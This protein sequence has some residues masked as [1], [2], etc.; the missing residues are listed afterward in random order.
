[1]SFFVRSCIARSLSRERA[2]AIALLRTGHAH[3]V[4]LPHHREPVVRDRRADA[5]EDE[6]DRREQAIAEEHRRAA[7]RDDDVEVERVGDRDLVA[8]RARREHEPA[9]RVE[10]GAAG[11]EQKSQS[12]RKLRLPASAVREKIRGRD[13]GGRED[14]K[15]VVRAGGHVPTES[16]GCATHE[17]DGFLGRFDMAEAWKRARSRVTADTLSYARNAGAPYER[18]ER[19][20]GRSGASAARRRHR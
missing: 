6:V 11:K 20:E 9:R 19:R 12:R 13:R 1:M 7:A 2:I 4:E 8:A 16:R 10:R 15:D 5:R 14:A 3:H 17:A 18:S